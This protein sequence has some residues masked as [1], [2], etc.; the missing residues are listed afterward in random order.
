MTDTPAL[1]TPSR[2]RLLLWLLACAQFTLIIDFVM[3]MPL[4]PLVMQAF[5]V[6]P[7]AFAAAV[8]VYAWFAG[9]SGFFAA[10]YIDRFDRRRLLLI[11]FGLF[12]LANLCCA[13]APSFQVLLL[14]RAFTGLA[15]GVVGAVIL[16]IVGDVI[17]QSRRGAAMGMV[18]TAFPVAMVAGVPLGVFL[19]AHFGWQAPFFMIMGLSVLAW[20]PASRVVPSL[21]VHLAGG[22]TPLARVLPELFHLVSNRR[23]VDA[24]LLTA[25]VMS[26]SMMIIPFFPAMLVS[27]HGVRPAELSY[28]YMV[29]GLATMFTARFIGRMSDRHGKPRVFRIVAT[30]AAAPMLF[31]THF[32]QWPLVA[33]ICFFPCFM[34][35]VSGRGIPMQALQTTVPEP[36]KRGAFLSVNAAVQSVATGMGAWLGGLMVGMEGGRLVGFGTNG[37]VAA[38]L[39]CFAALWVA[40]VKPAPLPASPAA[41]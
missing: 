11:T 26:S 29:G 5:D 4:G 34:V 2:E 19:A 13:L 15:A 1:L 23:H 31:L 10:T 16:A 30:A 25:L 7:A 17:P 33:I 18:M 40:R 22:V 12:A 20:L 9:L 27:N 41:A 35:L 36:H 24:F 32:P 21:T 28:I 8:S 37:W 3:M 14:A 39:T 6:G 38:F